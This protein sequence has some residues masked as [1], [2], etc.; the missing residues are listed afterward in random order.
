MIKEII[1]LLPEKQRKRGIWVAFSVLLRAILDFAGVAALIPILLVVAKQ[2]G[3]RGMMLALCGAVL[4]FVLLKNALVAFLARVQ[5]RYQLEIYREFSRRMFANY[6]HRGLLFLKGK[7]SV[8]LGHE[9]NYVC[10]MFSSCVLA[11]VFCMAGE[12]VLVLLMVTALVVWEP[13]AGFLLCASFLPLTGLYVGLVR[14]R[15][16]RYG[17]EELEA[18]R[19]QSR[20]VVEAYRGYAE[21]EIA[22]A[23]HTSLASFDQGMEF[24]VH[25]RLRMEVYQLFPFFLSE[26]AVVAGLALLIGTG[27]GDLGL[28]SGVFAVAAFRLIPAVRAVLNSWVTLQNAS[29]TITVVKEGISDKLQQGTQNQ[30]PF[31]LKQNIELRKLSFAFPD[32]HTLFSNLT[33][34]ISCG[35]RIGVRGASGSGKSTLFN[36]M[37]GFFPPTSGEILIDGRKLTSANRSEWHKLVG[38]VP[39]EIFIIEGTLADNI[40]LGQTQVDHIKMIQV[41]EQVQLKEWA[42]ELPQG[43]DTPLGEYGSRLSGGQKQRIGIARALY[44]EAEVLFFDEATSALDNKTEQEINHAL[45]TLSLQHRE[46]TLIIIAHRES[47]LAFCDRIFDLDS[48][49]I[50]TKEK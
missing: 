3:G 41:L 20:T 37:L 48:G 28:V 29:H 36:L 7:S 24:I 44:K 39:Q 31:T 46:L 32:G 16:R 1:Q 22:R 21:L 2:D 27:S 5:S 4:L 34:S 42:N 25:N 47:S 8:Q 40:A 26:V 30:T 15:L 6:Y 18:R 38:Y 19:K 17:M 33:L 11:P 13:L 10:Y 43:L 45:E 23:F 12:A 35:E 49:N 50:Y 9:V 14:K